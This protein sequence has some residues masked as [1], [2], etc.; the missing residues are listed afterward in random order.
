[1]WRSK[2]LEQQAA[3][4]GWPEMMKTML[5]TVDKIFG[6]CHRI[7]CTSPI[8]SLW[9]PHCLLRGF[10]PPK[11]H[12]LTTIFHCL[13]HQIEASELWSQELILSNGN[14]GAPPKLP[15]I[16][17]K[18]Y[19]SLKSDQDTNESSN[20]SSLVGRSSENICSSSG[21]AHGKGL[22]DL[23]MQSKF[24]AL[25]LSQSEAT[26]T[27][28]AHHEGK[29]GQET[30]F[31]PIPVRYLATTMVHFLNCYF[32]YLATN[33]LLGRWPYLHTR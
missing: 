10:F 25:S 9:V 24:I 11:D 7:L 28:S 29:G 22:S 6:S 27:T 31:H 15:N 30:L 16:S 18:P 32:S 17:W 5:V 12:Q 8:S 1:M 20:H 13:W 4:D 3:G 33:N 14:D 23:Q 19:N 26:A 21:G 2:A